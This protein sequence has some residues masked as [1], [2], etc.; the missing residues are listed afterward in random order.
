MVFDNFTQKVFLWDVHSSP[1]LL[2]VAAEGAAR[3]AF[4]YKNK[5][6]TRKFLFSYIILYQEDISK[7]YI[8]LKL[9]L[10]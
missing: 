6:K 1:P 9:F 5:R 2:L 3:G 4:V 10:Q 8:A 7:I